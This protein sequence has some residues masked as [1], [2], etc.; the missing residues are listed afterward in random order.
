MRT[1]RPTLLVLSLSAALLSACGGGDEGVVVEEKD[2]EPSGQAATLTVSSASDTALNGVYSTSNINT[3]NVTKVNPIGSDPE[4][5]RFKFDGPTQV[6]TTRIMGG[7]IRYL[8]G[9]NN[10]QV[11]F[12]AINGVEFTLNGSAGARVDRAGNDIDFTGAVLTGTQGSITLTGSVP[13]RPDRPEG[14]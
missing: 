7:D 13:M 8:P 9:T 10:L 11:A 3:N 4:T 6:G 5:C 14:C 2:P 1:L 12:I